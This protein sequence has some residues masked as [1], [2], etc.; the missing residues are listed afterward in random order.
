MLS[1]FFSLLGS[2]VGLR[3]LD[4]WRPDAAA[5]YGNRQSSQLDLEL[6]GLCPQSKGR[7]YGD[8]I[9]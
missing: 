8:V 5:R 3:L 6:E 7:A 4:Q 1:P 2:R 9:V